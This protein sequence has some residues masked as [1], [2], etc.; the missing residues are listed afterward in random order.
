MNGGI[1]IFLDEGSPIYT[2]LLETKVQGIMPS[3]VEKLLAE[4]ETDLRDSEGA[5]ERHSGPYNNSLIELG[6]ELSGI[7]EDVGKDVK[8]FK[9]G[10]EIMAYR[11]I[12]FGTYAEY[13]CLHEDGMVVVFYTPF[14]K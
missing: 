2:L 13:T 1:R 14:I 4:I 10:D 5:S 9:K 7:I 3:Y 12:N 6:V 8:R 11:G